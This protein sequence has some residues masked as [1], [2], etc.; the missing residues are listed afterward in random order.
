MEW[1]NIML[2]YVDTDLHPIDG[3]KITF[4]DEGCKVPGVISL[5][6]LIQ[7]GGFSIGSKVNPVWGGLNEMTYMLGDIHRSDFDKTKTDLTFEY[8]FSLEYHEDSNSSLVYP[9][10]LSNFSRDLLKTYSCPVYVAKDPGGAEFKEMVNSKR[11]IFE[12][13]GFYKCSYILNTFKSSR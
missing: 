12:L 2:E 4:L 9:D 1:V 7:T 8:V 5:S 6:E 13:F 3:I 10:A 11:P